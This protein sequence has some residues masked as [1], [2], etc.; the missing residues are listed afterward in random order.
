MNSKKPWIL[1]GFLLLIDCTCTHN[2]RTFS[3]Q[4]TKCTD[5]QQI[6]LRFTGSA[7]IYVQIFGNR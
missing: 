7:S 5:L 1:H 2:N 3:P 6:R 4:S